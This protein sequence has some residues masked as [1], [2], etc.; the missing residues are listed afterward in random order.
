MAGQIT[1]FPDSGG[2]ADAAVAF[3]IRVASAGLIF[4][5]Q[6]LLARL[7]GLSAYGNYVTLWTWL[8]AV[9]SFGALGFAESSVRFLPRYQARGR[10]GLVA[11]FWR[12]GFLAV[13]SASSVLAITA[14]LVALIFTG[15]GTPLLIGIFVAIGLPFLAMEYYLEGIARSFGWFRLTTIPVYIIRPVLIAAIALGLVWW[16]VELSFTVIGAV[17]VG[18][19]A[20]VS[21]G[22]G[23]VIAGRLRAMAGAQPA[24]VAGR[25]KRVWLVA[26]VPLL[27][28]SGLEDLLTY[29]DVLIVA[30]MLPPEDVSLYF[31]GARTLALAN[32]VYFAL[33]LVSGRTFA[34]ALNHV[35][36]QVLQEKV[37]GASRA[38]FWFTL[39][40]VLVTLLAGQILLA[41]FGPEFSAAFPVMVI[42]AVGLVARS[43]AGQAGELLIVAGKQR[44]TIYLTGGVV[45]ANVILTIALVPVLGIYGAAR[46]TSV[47]MAARAGALIFVVRHTMGLRVVALGLPRLRPAKT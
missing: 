41:A 29:S 9:G 23:L 26:S 18:A 42:L 24:P 12:F 13:V 15:G 30:L 20:T 11:G 47:A 36:K 4:G 10:N 45:V 7:M 43:L 17:V 5:L 19:M 16:G 39:G 35:D 38:T 6:V 40:A 3:F 25:R 33:Y 28:V 34:L 2:I 32:F 14:A 8:M 44:E 1:N 27:L 21:I 37:L 22:L 31:A 46:G